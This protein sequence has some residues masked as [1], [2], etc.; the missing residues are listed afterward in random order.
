LRAVIDVLL[1]LVVIFDS[2]ELLTEV[3]DIAL[4]TN[5]WAAGKSLPSLSANSFSLATIGNLTV[6][7]LAH[8]DP[9]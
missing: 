4:L 2:Q 5:Q 3:Y 1:I 8:S 7:Y 9:P 6:V